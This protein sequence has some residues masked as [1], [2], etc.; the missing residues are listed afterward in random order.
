VAPSNGLGA[1]S[2]SW[3]LGPWKVEPMM[4]ASGHGRSYPFSLATPSD[5]S[6]ERAFSGNVSGGSRSIP[7]LARPA[8]FRLGLARQHRDEFCWVFD[9]KDVGLASHD[10][11][12]PRRKGCEI[13]IGA[14]QVSAEE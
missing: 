5:S 3:G 8:R 1:P 6:G 2:E 14:C 4:I 12:I 9:T 10:P 7:D 11:K 13:A